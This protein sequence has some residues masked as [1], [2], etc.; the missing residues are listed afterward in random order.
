[1]NRRILAVALYLFGGFGA[2]GCGGS[3]APP[4]PT[5]PTPPPIAPA[6]IVSSG[7][8]QWSPCISSGCA[9]A[10]SVQNIGAGCATGLT[11]VVRFFDTANAQ[12]GSD[13]QLGLTG[14]SLSGRTVRPNEILAV[15]TFDFVPNAT[16]NRVSTYSLIPAWTNVRCP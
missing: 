8:G 3:S 11:V 10:A 4:T 5:A 12:V 9:F 7:Q 2:L 15:A 13:L 1:M 14:G 16:R 6:N